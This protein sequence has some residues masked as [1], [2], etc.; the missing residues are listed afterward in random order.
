MRPKS[1]IAKRLGRARR[2]WLEAVKK[3]EAKGIERPKVKKKTR[4]AGV[5]RGPPA[6]I[7]VVK[8][9][10]PEGIEKP[11]ASEI[12]RLE[13]T[14]VEKPI[15]KDLEKLEV[16]RELMALLKIKEIKDIRH[17]PTPIV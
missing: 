16:D 14:E 4:R 7:K 2:E 5:L 9:E 15:L 17:N 13:V 11:I 10:K 12:E 8:I 6:E 1:E 3:A